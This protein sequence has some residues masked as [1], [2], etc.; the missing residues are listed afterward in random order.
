MDRRLSP[1]FFKRD[2]PMVWRKHVTVGGESAV[3]GET[4]DPAKFDVGQRQRLWCGGQAIYAKDW[5]GRTDIAPEVPETLETAS[6]VT[7]EAQKA[8]WYEIS[9]PWL[10]EPEKVRGK[11]AAEARAAE[12]EA[13]AH[14][15]A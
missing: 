3:P 9:A 8:G 15:D 10:D 7:I 12:I 13:M 6:L 1:R 14:S 11:V 5:T 2:E 4:V